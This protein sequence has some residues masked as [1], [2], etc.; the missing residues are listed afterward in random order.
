MPEDVR[1]E[2][3]TGTWE[4]DPRTWDA[5]T[6]VDPTFGT[7]NTESVGKTGWNDTRP[8]V[9]QE[10]VYVLNRVGA[11]SRVGRTDTVPRPPSPPLLTYRL[12]SW[13]VPVLIRHPSVVTGRRSLESEVSVHVSD[14]P[15]NRRL[16]FPTSAPEGKYPLQH[17]PSIS[18]P[19]V[20]PG[21]LP[22]APPTRGQVERGSL[23][24]RG[25]GE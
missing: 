24:C 6:G 23:C 9:P 8:R 25:V 16:G 7:G 21:I 4:G 1:P 5:T 12:G 10:D 13:V 19:N 3:P 18:S 15:Q 2:R 14:V 22:V 17:R 20:P 11:V